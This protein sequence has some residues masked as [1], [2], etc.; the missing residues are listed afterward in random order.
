MLM[1]MLISINAIIRYHL[2]VRIL[3]Q[4]SGEAPSKSSTLVLLSLSRALLPRS[5]HP[6]RETPSRPQKRPLSQSCVAPKSLALRPSP[7]SKIAP[8]TG[9]PRYS[10]Q[11]THD[12]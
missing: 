4:P 10:R 6:A 7:P 11:E 8:E 12:E 2:R 3:V 5:S 9:P 1:L